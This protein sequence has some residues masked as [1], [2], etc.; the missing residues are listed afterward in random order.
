MVDL[1]KGHAEANNGQKSD[2]D[3]TIDYLFYYDRHFG[4]LAL[5]LV[6]RLKVGKDGLE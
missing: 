1:G 3:D 5:V 4:S 6:L 2:T